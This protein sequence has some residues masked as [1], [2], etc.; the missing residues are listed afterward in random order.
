MA[1]NKDTSS[2]QLV[3]F[4]VEAMEDRKG[5]DITYIDFTKT[6]NTIASYFVICHGTSKVQVDALADGVIENTLEK[7][8]SKPWK[9]EGYENAEWILLDYADVVVHIFQE[10]TRKFYN[11]EGLWGDMEVTRIANK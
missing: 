9:K 5:L 7:M 1:K 10:D 6:P 8:K 2:K 4:I 3:E 11:I